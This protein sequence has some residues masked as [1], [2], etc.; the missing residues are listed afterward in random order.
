[1]AV[2]KVWVKRGNASAT[3]VPITLDALV[4]DVRDAVIRKYLNSLGRTFDAPDVILRI[5][6]REQGD[7]ARGERLLAPDEPILQL[8]NAFYPGGQTLEE[9]LI[10]DVPQKRTPKPSPRVGTQ[11][12]PYLIAEETNPMEAGEYFPPMPAVRSPGLNAHTAQPPGHPSNNHV[13]AMTV[14]TTGQLPSLPSPGGRSSRHRPK[15]GRQQTCSSA[16]LQPSH[17]NPSLLGMK[18]LMGSMLLC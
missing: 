7:H 9:A 11:L 4:D 13:Q 8:L 18:S 2:Q 16:V 15:V 17:P 5:R 1:M 10:I 12:Q 6:P 3:Q 14:L